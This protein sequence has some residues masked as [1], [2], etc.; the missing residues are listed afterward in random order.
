M[1]VKLKGPSH[2]RRPGMAKDSHSTL[3]H[4]NFHFLHLFRNLGM[5]AV[6]P[7][8]RG[9]GVFKLLCLFAIPGDATNTG[10]VLDF[11]LI[12]Q[13]GKAASSLYIEE[14]WIRD[15][16]DV[17]SLEI[18]KN[19]LWDKQDYIAE[20]AWIINL[21]LSPLQHVCCSTGWN[22]SIFLLN[23][24]I[25]YLKRIQLWVSRLC[26]I[27]RTIHSETR[28]FPTHSNVWE[29]PGLDSIEK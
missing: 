7:F 17:G 22:R 15:R 8:H 3:N 1:L 9:V 6:Q 29:F 10:F 12:P 19:R 21:H 4:I 23:K 26:L 27:E 13:Q 11:C 2:S 20:K 14:V 25:Q 28:H 5:V 16:T 18:M 24:Q